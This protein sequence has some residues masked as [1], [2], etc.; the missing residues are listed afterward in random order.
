MAA[1]LRRRRA[2]VAVGVVLTLIAI[3]AVVG[4][5][6]DPFDQDFR[7]LRNQSSVKG[8]P[9]EL[10]SRVGAV[11]GDD[12][13]PIGV[14]L[15]TRAEDAPAFR[16]AVLERDCRVG[17]RRA[18]TPLSRDEHAL[19]AECLRRVAAGEPTGGLV[20]DVRSADRLLPDK[21]DEKLAL[22]K[23][24]QKLLHDPSIQLL[25]EEERKQV[26]AW[27]PP[28]DL[29][30]LTVKDLPDALIRPFRELDGTVGRV[31]ALFPIRQGYRGWDGRHLLQVAEVEHQVPLPDG[32][33]VDVA[34]RESVFAAMLRAISHDGPRAS[35]IALI[36]V[37][38]LVV[39]SFRR[40]SRVVLVVGSLVVGVIWMLGAAALLGLRL[41]FLNFVAI[42]ITFGIGVD[43]AVN[44][45]A[46]LETEPRERHSRALAESGSAVA[47][48]SMTTIIGYM[49]LLL[50]NSGA[51]RS[52]GQL[53]ALGEVSCLVAALVIVPVF[54]PILAKRRRASG[55][56]ALGK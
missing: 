42:P 33:V 25:D 17:E 55:H 16:V 15:L 50:A 14:A 40:A 52:F 13:D 38:A 7:K 19:D 4:V 47:L 26:D 5:A 9:G 2:S 35:L 30:K 32:T 51:L 36:S 45:V 21:Q 11:F 48:C 31:A 18:R 22:V 53:A 3:V 43:Y 34:G 20:T 6:G 27:A 44:V 28:E 56:Q 12:I 8:G 1:L 41:N 39:A 10:Y 49:S 54:A 29:T 23:H 46:R 24:L 37:L